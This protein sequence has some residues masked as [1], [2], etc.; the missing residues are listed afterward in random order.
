M[1]AGLE[2]ANVITN[3]SSTDTGVNLDIHVVTERNDDLLD[4]LSKLTRWGKDKSL[5]LANLGVKL[6]K[7][8]NSEG[9]SFTLVYKYIYRRYKK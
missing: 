1:D 9:G 2:R 3:G 7:G 6:S 8:P 4:L 5:T